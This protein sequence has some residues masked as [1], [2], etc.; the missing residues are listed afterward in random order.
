MQKHSR[1]F[2]RDH[3]SADR[4]VNVWQPTA[5]TSSSAEGPANEF[6][7]DGP[8]RRA[9]ARRAR[10]VNT[11][12]AHTRLTISLDKSPGS[13]EE[14]PRLIIP[15]QNKD[16]NC[17]TIKRFSRNHSANNEPMSEGATF[18]CPQP[19][20]RGLLSCRIVLVLRKLQVGSAFH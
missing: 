20:Q 19:P 7:Q 4:S 12:R 14:G 16:P 3:N 15:F 6:I 2:V 13:P 18:V 5:D 17:A 8:P 9:V 1:S 11:E 10:G